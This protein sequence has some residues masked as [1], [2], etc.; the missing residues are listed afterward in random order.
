A[1]TLG[2]AIVTDNE[3]EFARIDGLPCE[4]WLRDA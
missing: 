2:Y 4:N 3:R 1:M